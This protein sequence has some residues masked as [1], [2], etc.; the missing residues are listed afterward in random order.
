MG[1]VG[2][3]GERPAGGFKSSRGIE[4]GSVRPA[5]VGAERGIPASQE[6]RRDGSRG[7]NL[8]GPFSPKVLTLRY[9]PPPPAA[10]LPEMFTVILC[11]PLTH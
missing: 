6:L 9:L 7:L 11:E 8:R 1:K 2:P 5:A 3:K 10:A 4:E